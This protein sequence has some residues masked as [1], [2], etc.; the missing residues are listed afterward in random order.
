VGVLGTAVVYNH[1]STGATPG[2]LAIGGD[3]PAG[4]QIAIILIRFDG[5]STTVSITGLSASFG[6]VIF[7]GQ[8]DGFDSNCALAYVEVEDFGSG[9]TITPTFN[10]NAFYD[11]RIFGIVFIDG[12][13]TSTEAAWL[14]DWDVKYS[15]GVATSTVDTEEGDVVLSGLGNYAQ[16][17]PTPA[18]TTSIIAPDGISSIQQRVVILDDAASGTASFSSGDSYGSASAISIISGGSTDTVIE[19]DAESVTISTSSA[20]VSLNKTV[21]GAVETISVSTFIAAPSLRLNAV[22]EQISLGT[23]LSMVSSN[24]SISAQ[25]ES[26]E[27]VAADAT[28]AAG[29]AIGVLSEQIQVS[30]LHATVAIDI[31]IDAQRESL[32]LSSLSAQIG[33]AK[34]IGANLESLTIT[35]FGATLVIDGGVSAHLEQLT[36]S[37]FK[38]VIDSAVPPI[39]VSGLEYTIS[40]EK[41]HYTMPVSRLHFTFRS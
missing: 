11:Q 28:V 32:M 12:V 37:T 22:A 41:I 4:S 9:H 30:S 7:L 25:V 38:A 34:N 20:N 6:D 23:F 27:L 1:E 19:A 21:S 15:N 14:R 24:R 3:V 18:D 33:L 40:G 39:L 16:T 29:V 26:I 31:A 17:P 36:L 5:S 10:E 8:T 13:D 2:A 35:P